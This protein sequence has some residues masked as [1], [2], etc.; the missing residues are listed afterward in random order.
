MQDYISNAIS[1]MLDESFDEEDL[2]FEMPSLQRQNAITSSCC[3]KSPT[4]SQISKRVFEEKE[5]PVCYQ[6]GESSTPLICGHV[7][8]D[9]CI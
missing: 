5:C 9:G 2:D 8:C 3:E 1:E 7:Y 4:I 6:E